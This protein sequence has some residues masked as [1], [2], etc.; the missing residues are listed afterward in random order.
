MKTTIVHV[1]KPVMPIGALVQGDI[2]LIH[3]APVIIC[4]LPD[5]KWIAIDIKSGEHWN[6]QSS[7]TLEDL[8]AWLIWYNKHEPSIDL[9]MA[10]FAEFRVA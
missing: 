2:V 4:R 6:T 3:S 8:R 7:D 9:R 10:S 1:P 5:S